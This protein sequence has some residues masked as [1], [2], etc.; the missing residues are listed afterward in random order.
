MTIIIKITV[1]ILDKHLGD[2]DSDDAKDKILQ[3]IV[4]W[5]RTVPYVRYDHF[6]KVKF[7]DNISLLSL[8]ITIVRKTRG[9][10]KNGKDDYRWM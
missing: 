4:F 2:H 1:T 7:R 6:W 3:I 8:T 10:D 9:D 5:E